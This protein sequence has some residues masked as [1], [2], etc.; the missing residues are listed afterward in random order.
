MRSRRA[1]GVLVVLVCALPFLVRL[2]YFL[3]TR[4]QPYFQWNFLV[5]YVNHTFA[6][7]LAAG[8]GGPYAL[9]RSP[10]Y[11][12]AVSA[13]YRLAGIE[14]LYARVAQW[15]LGGLG[16]LLTYRLGLILFDRRVAMA[17]LVMSALFVPAICYEGELLEQP[18]ATFL[19]VAS[20]CLLA[21]THLDRREPERSA[22]ATSGSR[23]GATTV[24]ALCF[25]GAALLRPELLL[26]LPLLLASLTPDSH[27]RPGGIR[28]LVVFVFVCGLM[29]LPLWRPDIIINVRENHTNINA[30][31]NLHLGNNPQA[32]GHDARFP[33][34][35]ELPTDDPAARRDH[36]TGLDLAGIRYAQS[37]TGAGLAS[38]APFWL[39]M[40]LGFVAAEP[41]T[42]LKLLGIKTLLFF[43]GYLTG[44]QKDLYFQRE[45][46]W[47]LWALMWCVG[48]CFPMGL[49]LPLAIVGA[50]TRMPRA[51]RLMILSVPAGC[52]MTVLAFFYDARFLMPAVPFIILLACHALLRMLDAAREGAWAAWRAPAVLAPLLI[53]CNADWLSTHRVNRAAEEFR[54]G[55]MHQDQGDPGG[56]T[57]AYQRA[58]AADP[59]FVPALDNLANIARSAGAVS[60]TIDFLQGLAATERATP[61]LMRTLA[62]LQSVHGRSRE[63]DETLRRAIGLF[64]VDASVRM[65]LADKLMAEGACDRALTIAHQVLSRDAGDRRARACAG[66]CLQA[67]GR[68]DEAVTTL[69]EGL[70]RAPDDIIMLG[71][72]GRAY[73]SLGRHQDEQRCYLRVLALDPG[74]ALAAYELALSLAAAGHHAEALIRARDAQRLGHPQAAE[75]VRDLESRQSPE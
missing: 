23:L 59:A 52:F 60:T 15:L 73:G 21:S 19:L 10:W 16:C 7:D 29:A 57:A 48:L 56:A 28:R 30:A 71:L 32:T 55:T 65:D 4:S 37:R 26:A 41:G 63:S 75:L 9:Y 25:G 43:N 33:E 13:I 47:I 53:L 1:G 35:P 40:T 50:F 64:P 66:H 12:L 36:M 69:E 67:L 38:V 42:E 70:R 3:E 6:S 31:I 72:L 14:P 54:M 2:I 68:A 20:L 62:A 74:H 49:I 24:A 44:T 18:A 61:A 39:D 46:S 27:A 8:S 17:A 34:T 22:A 5:A 51:T 11:P 45:R 58:I